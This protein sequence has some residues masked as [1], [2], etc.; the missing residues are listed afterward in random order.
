MCVSAVQMMERKIQIVAKKLR[1]CDR[2]NNIFA[3][4]AHMKA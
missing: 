2:V 4:R 3:V 1:A